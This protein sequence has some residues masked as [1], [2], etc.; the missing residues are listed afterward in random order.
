MSSSGMNNDSDHLISRLQSRGLANNLSQPAPNNTI[1]IPSLKAKSKKNSDN[2]CIKT[3]KNWVLP[4]RPKPGR[5]PSS[6]SNG[7]ADSKRKGK[8]SIN[9]ATKQIKQQSKPHPQKP[10]SNHISHCSINN[11]KINRPNTPSLLHDTSKPVSA[12]NVRSVQSVLEDE[13]DKATQENSLLKNELSKLVS[14]LKSLRKQVMISSPTETAEP[15]NSPVSMTQSSSMASET[16]SFYSPGL[17]SNSNNSLPDHQFINNNYTSSRMVQNYSSPI[18]NSI[19][20]NELE[21]ISRKRTHEFVESEDHGLSRH[22]SHIS[23]PGVD[24][25]LEDENS[26][27]EEHEDKHMKL[28]S[29]GGLHHHVSL[30]GNGSISQSLTSRTPSLINPPSTTASQ[31]TPAKISSFFD[32]FIVKNED[33]KADNEIDEFVAFINDDSEI[34]KKNNLHKFGKEDSD[35]NSYAFTNLASVPSLVSGAS[36]LILSKHST[37][38]SEYD[39]DSVRNSGQISGV[40]SDD[41]YHRLIDLP[42]S[43]NI[44]DSSPLDSQVNDV[45][46]LMTCNEEVD[47][48]IDF[49]FFKD[50]ED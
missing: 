37:L 40:R 17:V 10:A 24:D 44:V 4:P 47:K 18:S 31:P 28:S 6:N 25:L 49:S 23:H 21:P 42:S 19:D 2:F 46:K 45:D 36:S 32:D 8:K 43:L 26:I 15:Q 39:D 48:F 50:I 3:S 16:S 14:D 20:D 27:D 9:C 1:S 38:N 33:S 34:P 29:T 30:I 41:Y 22:H 12:N 13:L 35:T 11:T 5:K 7:C